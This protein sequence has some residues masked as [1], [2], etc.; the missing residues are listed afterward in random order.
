MYSK[1][2][3][4]FFFTAETGKLQWEAEEGGQTK[5]RPTGNRP[6]FIVMETSPIL[7]NDDWCVVILQEAVKKYEEVVHNLKFAKELQKTIGALTQDVRFMHLRS[8]ERSQAV[9]HVSLDLWFLRSCWRLSGKLLDKRR[10]WGLKRR[11]NVWAWCSRCNTS[12]TVC[13][14]RTSGGTSATRDNI[15]VTCPHRTLRACWIWRHYWDAK[16]IIAWGLC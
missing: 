10:W 2:F 15:P 3:Y 13:R 1:P 16:E 11:G 9:L 6:F 5:S 7:G 8:R 12:S 14:E 4:S